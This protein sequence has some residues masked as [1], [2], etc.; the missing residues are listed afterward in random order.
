MNP[1]LLLLATADLSGRSHPHVAAP[2]KRNAARLDGGR[3]VEE[4]RYE[5]Q[6]WRERVG[7]YRM[8]QAQIKRE[9]RGGRN[10]WLVQRG[11]LRSAT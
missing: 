8:R 9:D 2:P 10:L 7:D 3:T 5:R 6:W 11:G 4:M 1:S